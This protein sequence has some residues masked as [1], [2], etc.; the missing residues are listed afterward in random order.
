M[1][2]PIHEKTEEE[3]VEYINNL[4]PLFESLIEDCEKTGNKGHEEIMQSAKRTLANA[5][6][7]TGKVCEELQIDP[8][9]VSKTSH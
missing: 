3:L 6:M 9:K 5:K 2:K 8:S 4:L 1:D 7:I